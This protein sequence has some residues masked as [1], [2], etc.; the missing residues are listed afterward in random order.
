MGGNVILVVGNHRLRFSEVE[1]W[2][3]TNSREELVQLSGLP[4]W[5]ALWKRTPDQRVPQHK[6]KF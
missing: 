2:L 3:K 1:D 5:S 6:F 4:S